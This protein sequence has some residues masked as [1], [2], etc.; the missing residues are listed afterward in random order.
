MPVTVNSFID[1]TSAV[2]VSAVDW[3]SGA[4]SAVTTAGVNFAPTFSNPV[5]ITGI[6]RLLIAWGIAGGLA[7][8]PSI[9]TLKTPVASALMKLSQGVASTLI[10]ANTIMM[11][12]QKGSAFVAGDFPADMQ[13]PVDLSLAAG[14][15]IGCITT[16]CLTMYL[17]GVAATANVRWRL[18]L[19]R[20]S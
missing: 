6:Y 14:D 12:W 20:I 18:G 7:N 5:P 13:Y 11:T 8:S 2:A 9:L 19:T 10:A 4:S 17:D 16:S 3:T 15:R 1:A